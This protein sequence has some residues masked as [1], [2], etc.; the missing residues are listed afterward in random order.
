LTTLAP[1]HRGFFITFEGGEGAGKSTQAKRLAATLAAEGFETI[2]TREPGGTA[3]AEAIRDLLLDPAT[4]LVPLA[5]TLMHFAA[6]ADHAARVIRPAIARGAVVICDRFYDSTM[7]YQGYGMGVDVGAIATLVRLIGLIPDV[8]LFMELSEP[9]AKA[10]L[11]TRGLA[12]DRYDLMD[13]ETRARI[14]YGFR[15]VAVAEPERCVIIDASPG[16][17]EV[18]TAILAA[19]KFRLTR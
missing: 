11:F 1:G 4:D 5:D 10:R 7:A 8:S 12:P 14:A 13:N 2:L 16:P 19:I 6:R 9:K 15:S 3:G 17:D 18:A